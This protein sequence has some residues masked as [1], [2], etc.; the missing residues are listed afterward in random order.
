MLK[1]NKKNW[2]SKNNYNNNNNFNN[3]NNN[4]NQEKV[5]TDPEDYI[6]DINVNLNTTS[7]EKN[8]KGLWINYMIGHMQY[9]KQMF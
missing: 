9:M 3:N 7:Y 1:K 8:I 5:E 4:F 2:N 6:K